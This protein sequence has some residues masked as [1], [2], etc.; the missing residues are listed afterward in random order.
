MLD[1]LACFAFNWFQRDLCLQL[2]INIRCRR[3]SANTL[4]VEFAAKSFFP[5]SPK[6]KKT[7][8][9][10][11]MYFGDPRRRGLSSVRFDGADIESNAVKQT[12]TETKR[13]DTRPKYPKRCKEK[14]QKNLSRLSFKPDLANCGRLTKIDSTHWRQWFSTTQ[15]VFFWSTGRAIHLGWTWAFKAPFSLGHTC[16]ANA[17]AKERKYM[18][19]LHQHICKRK[20]KHQRKKWK[21]FHF[22]PLRLQF[23][24]VNRGNTNANPKK[25]KKKQVPS[26]H[27]IGSK[28]RHSEVISSSLFQQSGISLNLRTGLTSHATLFNQ[29]EG[30]LVFINKQIKTSPQWSKIFKT[31]DGVG[32]N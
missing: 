14:Y 26:I 19:E 7:D 20:R 13:L 30:V 31:A 15:N 12:L 28:P 23:T 2:N 5:I 27:R 24:R 21:K 8:L 29:W 3:N 25:R 1:W 18:C 4:S 11:R 22:L 32:Q 6:I 16:D 10:R 9:Q 17:N